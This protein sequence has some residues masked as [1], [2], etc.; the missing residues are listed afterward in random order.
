MTQPIPQKSIRK[1]ENCGELDMILI[2]EKLCSECKKEQEQK[3]KSLL[4]I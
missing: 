3:R 4:E 2:S 1:C